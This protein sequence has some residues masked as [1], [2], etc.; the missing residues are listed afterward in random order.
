[1]KLLGKQEGHETHLELQ[2]GFKEMSVRL[3]AEG[4]KQELYSAAK[5]IKISAEKISTFH[6]TMIPGKRD[7][8][9]YIC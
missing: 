6:Q 8:A 2:E 9:E 1:M 7:R 4:A 3:S 5:E